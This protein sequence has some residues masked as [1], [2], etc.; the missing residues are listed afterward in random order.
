MEKALV[1]NAKI[2][3]R[4]KNLVEASIKAGVKKMIAQ[5]IAF[6]YEPSE[7]PHTEESAL[8]NFED[9]YIWRDIKSSRQ[10]LEQ[11][12]LNAPFIGIKKWSFIRRRNRF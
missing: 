3:D 2:R 12:V 8:L 7:L 10:S 5:S 11:Q 6:V 9:P 4:N 1:S